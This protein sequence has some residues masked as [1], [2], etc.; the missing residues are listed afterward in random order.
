MASAGT[1]FAAA[2]PKPGGIWGYLDELEMD[3]AALEAEYKRPLSFATKGSARLGRRHLQ[4]KEEAAAQRAAAEKEAAAAAAAAAAEEEAA[5][6]EMRQ[7]Q[8]AAR[9]RAELIKSLSHEG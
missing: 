1:V 4:V 3:R 2:A 9:K 8:R 7:A 5:A 6:A